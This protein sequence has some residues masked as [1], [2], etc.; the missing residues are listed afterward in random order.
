MQPSQLKTPF[1]V[2]IAVLVLIG[3]F[4]TAIY[5]LGNPDNFNNPNNSNNFNNFE[6]YE[7]SAINV[8]D[9]DTFVLNNGEIIRLL[10]VDTPEEGDSGYEEARDY[11]SSI[12][13]ENE[14]L[15]IER[16]GLDKYNRTLAW[17][18]SGEK[19]NE[20]LINKEI[21]DNNFGVIFEYESTNCSRVE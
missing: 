15:T 1:I 5:L 12:I 17:V 16:Q 13:S 14:N 10:C 6:N 9:G 19:N 3:C 4:A 11:L 7:S 8:I 18:Y 20:R 2:F 21:I